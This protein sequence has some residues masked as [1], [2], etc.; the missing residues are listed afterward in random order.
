MVRPFHHSNPL[1][2]D[3]HRTFSAPQEYLSSSSTS[4]PRPELQ[5]GTVDFLVPSAYWAPV[6]PKRLIHAFLSV[7]ADSEAHPRSSVENN[8]SPSFIPVI[9]NPETATRKPM[10]M[11]YVFALD[12]SL[13]AVQT[14]FLNS[15]CEIILD[16]LYGNE[17]STSPSWWNPESKLAIV[18]FDRELCFY[19]FSVWSLELHAITADPD[20]IHPTA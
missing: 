20:M 3:N 2:T 5:R 6:P 12:V 7:D 8:K 18:T 14:G 15:V 11:N 9:N 19:E 4:I 10:P 16:M 1:V 17:E 13:E